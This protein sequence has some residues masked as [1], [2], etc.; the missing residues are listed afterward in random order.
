MGGEVLHI[1]IQGPRL[2]P[3]VASSLSPWSPLDVLPPGNRQG[4]R[5]VGRTVSGQQTLAWVSC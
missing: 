1:V 5:S 4:K 2:M 3:S